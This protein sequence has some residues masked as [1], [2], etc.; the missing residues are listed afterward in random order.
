MYERC[1]YKNRRDNQQSETA[2]SSSDNDTPEKPS[3]PAEIIH[4]SSDEDTEGS[5]D[6]LLN[7]L[8][9]LSLEKPRKPKSELRKHR[10]GWRE[11]V[12]R[13]KESILDLYDAFDISTKDKSFEELYEKTALP[14]PKPVPLTK[15]ED[16]LVD[17]FLR[18]GQQGLIAQI[19]TA[20]IEYKDIYKLYP[21]TWLNDEARKEHRAQS[22][23]EK[24]PAIHC[25]STFFF[26]TFKDSGYTKIRRWTKKVDIFAKDLVFVPINQSYHWTLGVIHM[27]KKLVEIYDSMGG[28]HDYNVKLL[29]KYLSEEHMDKKKEALD[30]SEWSSNVPK[31]IPRQ[32]NMSDCGVF[33]CTFA[34]RLS[35][36]QSFDFSQQDMV[37]IR[38]R[39][40]L[41]IVRKRLSL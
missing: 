28:N 13:A 8:E 11:E 22:A 18:K 15:E 12:I 4:I 41:D 38:R 10:D 36:Q 19:K 17:S 39:M 30:Q 24:I 34:E 29:L 1:Y 2:S 14:K 20:V 6:S 21:E 26:S 5:I 35:R 7:Q 40:V 16:E 25:F 9:T 23:T 31:D 27:K 33:T 32:G 3:S 37:L